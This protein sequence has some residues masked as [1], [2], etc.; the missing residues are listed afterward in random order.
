[1][2]F[3]LCQKQP[4]ALKYLQVWHEVGEQDT[5]HFPETPKDHYR[6]IY[7]NAIDTVTKCIATRFD[8]VSERSFSAL[9]RVKTYL[10]STTV[11][12]KLNHL[13]MLHAHKDRTDRCSHPCRRS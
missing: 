9:K 1:M 7:F 6:R 3:L 13:L 2:V 10:R 11:D 5:H 4:T 12:S 8:A